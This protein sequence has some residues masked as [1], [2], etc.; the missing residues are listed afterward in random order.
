MFLDIPDVLTSAEIAQLRAIAARSVF[1]DG[2]MGSP[3][4]SPVKNNVRVG[5]QEANRQSAQ[6][7]GDALFRHE[8]FRTFAFPK[9]MMPPILTRYDTGMYYGIHVDSALMWSGQRTLRSDL[10]C[11][12]FI[13]D[14]SEYEGGALRL[15]L[16]S[17]DVR[18]K[19]KAGSA[20]VYPSTTV[21]EVEP[22]T[23]GARLIA[24][25][26][27]ESRIAN[28]ENRELLYELM[29]IG[30]AAGEKMDIETYTRLQ[31]VQQNLLRAWGSPD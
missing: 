1:I 24:M 29:E 4:A 5:D 11:T 16:G 28:S 6:L 3:D 30:A 18:V 20:I 14:A 26:F 15:K 22:V 17:S 19:G 27:I 31:R 13:G 9:A 7:V 21:H 8:D 23:S 2:K 12:V 25:T 10:S